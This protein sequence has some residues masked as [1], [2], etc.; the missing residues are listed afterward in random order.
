[1]RA[2]LGYVAECKTC[3]MLTPEPECWLSDGIQIR[4]SGIAG[5]GLFADHDISAAV[6]VSRL[7]GR[8]VANDALA[9]LME[10][11]EE[12]VDSVSVTDSHSLVLPP[13]SK[14]RCGN[15]SCDPNLWWIDPFSLA[16]RRPITAGEELTV[17]YGTLT[18]NPRFHI[19][20]R[21]GTTRCRALVT[22]A[23][24]MRTDLRKRYGDHWVPVLRD[25]TTSA[26]SPSS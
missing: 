10:S 24:W 13:G 7:G 16:T 20:C 5:Q 21:C 3:G 22:G 2:P 11:A 23:D 8:M 6:V 15:H 25:R 17:D 9:E 4:P 26:R 19:N 12:Y 1:M 18:D 14:N